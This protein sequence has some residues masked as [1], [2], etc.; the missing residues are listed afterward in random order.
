MVERKKIK[1][2]KEQTISFY[3]TKEQELQGI[4]KKLQ[5]IDNL[6]NEI[7]KAKQTLTEIQKS[8]EK[9]SILVNVGAGVLVEASIVN[10]KS[11]RITLPGNIMV[12]K[13]IKIVLQDINNRNEELVKLKKKFTDSYNN[14]MKTL[15]QITNAIKQMQQSNDKNLDANNVN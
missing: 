11:A 6:L 7:R 9:E 4:S 2:N 3:K 14:V 1:L 13:D 12:D 15:K 10:N 5:E 8:K